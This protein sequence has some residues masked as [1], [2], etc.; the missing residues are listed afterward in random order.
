MNMYQ[1]TEMNQLNE[2]LTFTVPLPFEAYELAGRFRR[3][4]SSTQ[5][6]KQVYLNTLAVYAVD[7]YMR[8]LSIETEVDK[9]DSRNLLDLK[10]MD[11]ADLQI[12]SIGRLECRPVLPDSTV[13]QVPIEVRD[14]R[15]G[16][17]AVQ[18]ERSLKQVTILGF[19]P[20][21]V[22]ELPL[23]QL[24]SLED[25]PEFLSQLR[26]RA[27][28]NL[29]QWFDDI[30]AEGW[31]AIDALL[32]SNHLAL[33]RGARNLTRSLETLAEPSALAARAWK[34][35]ELEQHDRQIPIVLVL[36]IT[37]RSQNEALELKIQAYP[38]GNSLCLP[39]D[40][41]LSVRDE[42]GTEICPV[43][44]SGNKDN[45]LQ[46]GFT[47]EPTEVFSIQVT[48]GDSSMTESFVI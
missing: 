4:Q 28:I 25:F 27:S 38:G 20:N 37:P 14:N 8:C 32:M 16:Y 39:P 22:A 21:A 46:L 30:F 5:K 9:S 48:L 17:V 3:Q 26:Q 2:P 41:Y 36:G 11:V 35:I 42:S 10:F 29:R 1:L 40:V 13:M 23:S 7:F 12:K 34:L 43:A 19:T 24:R 47:G 6:G 44:K 45:W 18:F 15:V 33:A 31:Q